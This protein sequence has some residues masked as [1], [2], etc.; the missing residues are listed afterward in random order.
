VTAP[1]EAEASALLKE[2][3]AVLVALR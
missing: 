2:L 3:R 1:M